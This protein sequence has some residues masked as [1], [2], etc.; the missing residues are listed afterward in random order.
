VTKRVASADVN[1]V[2]VQVCALLSVVLFTVFLSFCLVTVVVFV[3]MSI[4][5]RIQKVLGGRLLCCVYF[6]LS[7]LLHVGCAG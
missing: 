2:C 6:A 5:Q 1:A 7:I 3:R 4:E